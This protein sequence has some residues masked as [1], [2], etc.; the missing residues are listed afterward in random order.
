M[1]P[2]I[3]GEGSDAEDSKGV[4][5]DVAGRL[6]GSGTKY[7]AR[8]ELLVL[9]GGVMHCLGVWVWVRS[10]GGLDRDG[11]GFSERV[12][13]PTL[14]LHPVFSYRWWHIAGCDSEASGWAKGDDGEWR[15]STMEFTAVMFYN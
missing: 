6:V 7:P 12:T 4:D 14:L 1:W 3:R 15:S 2:D 9:W 11:H 10:S 8:L 13:E 5:E